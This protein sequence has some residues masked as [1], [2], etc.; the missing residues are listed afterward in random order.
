VARSGVALYPH[1]LA[2][3]CPDATRHEREY[4]LGHEQRHLDLALAVGKLVVEGEHIRVSHFLALG[5]L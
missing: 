1:A 3:V 4:H 5:S 2:Q